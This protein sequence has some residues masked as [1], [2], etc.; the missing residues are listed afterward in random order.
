MSWIG[1]VSNCLLLFVGYLN[2]IVV[3]VLWWRFE[4]CTDCGGG[5]VHDD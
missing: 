1:F 5:S 4:F 3:G 2:N